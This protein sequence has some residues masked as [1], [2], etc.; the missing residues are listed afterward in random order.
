MN[1]LFNKLFGQNMGQNTP[2][3]NQTGNQSSGDW[4]ALMGQ[5]QANPAGMAKQNGYQ[6]PEELSGDPQAMVKHLISTGQVSSPAM[7]R[8][9]PFLN[10][11]TGR[12]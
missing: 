1:P 9:Q 6:I 3:G 7:Q 12:R 5:L 11:L 2:L 4:N 10:L 8:V